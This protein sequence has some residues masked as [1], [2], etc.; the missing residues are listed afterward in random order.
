DYQPLLAGLRDNDSGVVA[1][2]VIVDGLLSTSAGN[3]GVRLQGIEP[4]V[5]KEFQDYHLWIHEGE[6]VDGAENEEMP[7][8]LGSKVAHDL[9]V[10]IGD[11]VV[12]TTTDSQGEMRRSLFFLRGVIK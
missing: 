1:A 11:R 12:M 4:E 2:R 10:K 5:E 3:A 7:I 9:D 6:Y 8:V